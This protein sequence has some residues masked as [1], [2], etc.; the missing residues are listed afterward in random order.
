MKDEY[1]AGVFDFVYRNAD[2]GTT[3]SGVNFWAFGGTGRPRVNGGMWSP[4]DDFIGDP[5]H[6][7]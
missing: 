7:R 3:L 1:Y 5:P 2:N 6:E 4:G